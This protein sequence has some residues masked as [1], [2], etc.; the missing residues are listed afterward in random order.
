MTTWE[1]R[2]RNFT[3]ISFVRPGDNP[4]EVAVCSSFECRIKFVPPTV[5]GT[6]LGSRIGKQDQPGVLYCTR[7]ATVVQMG[8][9]FEPLT[10]G[11][12]H[13]LVLGQTHRGELALRQVAIAVY[14]CDVDSPYY[15]YAHAISEL[16]DAGLVERPRRLDLWRPAGRIVRW[17]ARPA[18]LTPAGCAIAAA[19]REHEE[20]NR[21]HDE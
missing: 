15:T 21:A 1:G 5:V 8:G 6:F 20:E 13:W 3:H 18:I 11:D 14:V 4:A 9:L 2:N 10:L 7:C 16:V 12:M 17:L 19:R